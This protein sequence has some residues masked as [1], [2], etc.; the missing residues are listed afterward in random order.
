MSRGL[1][2]SVFGHKVDAIK[3]EAERLKE[4]AKTILGSIDALRAYEAFHKAIKFP[5]PIDP[6]NITL[7]EDGLTCV[8]GNDEPFAL[9]SE[10]FKLQPDDWTVE[11]VDGVDYNVVAVATQLGNMTFFVPVA[12]ATLEGVADETGAELVT[13]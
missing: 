7:G 5:V 11:T 1:K 13:A 2:K 4:Q 10:K 9:L 6:A 3:A 8:F 12:S